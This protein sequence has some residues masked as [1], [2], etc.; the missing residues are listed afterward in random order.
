MPTSRI[1]SPTAA[2]ALARLTPGKA[3]RRRADGTDE[4]VEPELLRPGDT[5]IIRPGE[6]VHADG[7]IVSGVSAL[8][9]A[10]ITGESLPADKGAGDQVFAGTVNLSGLLE[11]RVERA[12]R[13]T[14]LGKVRDLIVQAEQTRLP[15]T[16]LIDEYVRYYA[17]VVLMVA[18][19][20]WL[21]TGDLNRVA[22]LL[23]A[24]C[25]IAL[26]LATPSA[27]IAALSAAA[28]LG[29]LI[30]NVGDIEAMAR[31]EAFILDKTGT[32]TTG[33]LGVVRLGPVEGVKAADLVRIAASVEQHS[34]HPVA[35]AVQQLAARVRVP[36]AAATELHEEPGRGLRAK[37]EDEVVLVGNLAWLEANG[38]KEGDFPPV[39]AAEVQG[40]SLLYVACGPRPLGWIALQDQP[41]ADAA[42]MLAELAD[43]RVRHIA[44]VT[45][46]RQSVAERVARELK[47]EHYRGA[48]VPADK[49]A[50]VEEIK[51]RGLR[52]AFVGD[53]VND[54][55]AL[56]ASHL[57]I[58]MG[59][60]GSDVAVE[61]AT[62]ALLN[63][64]LN[65]LPFL[66]RLARSSRL[67]IMG[68]LALGG[69]FIVGGMALSAAGVLSPLAAA[70]LQVASSLA[71]VMNS[72]RLV[73]AGENVQ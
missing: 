45:G 43:L 26:I 29:V 18:A 5:L 30:K 23:V 63:N 25:P 62:I 47:L 17:P 6:N 38:W 67:V 64:R 52:T 10:N 41:R 1:S 50:Y 56:A 7:V 8:Q 51:R 65:R 15:F 33:E 71:V 24:A 19:I 58:A 28:R 59:A 3:R 22:A 34:N 72:A 21:A 35:L 68:N 48:C 13:D 73:R 55:P 27:T 46:D 57:G 49:V 14:T 2:Q 69:V 66:L 12:G 40:T 54:G 11:V 53:G 60:A 32:L 37:V 61:S 9:E 4:V 20:V 36:L 39:T 70:V 16:R 42:P 31:V 44:M